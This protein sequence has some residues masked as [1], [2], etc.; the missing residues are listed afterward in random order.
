M[1]GTAKEFWRKGG[2]H[3]H[4]Y[5]LLKDMQEDWRP[6]NATSANNESYEYNYASPRWLNIIS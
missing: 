4:D 3:R 1:C 6:K 5:K 2:Q